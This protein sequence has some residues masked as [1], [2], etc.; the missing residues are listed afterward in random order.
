[1]NFS[2][3][4]GHFSILLFLSFFHHYEKFERGEIVFSPTS[5]LSTPLTTDRSEPE[6]RVGSAMSSVAEENQQVTLKSINF[7]VFQ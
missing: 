4:F 7:V 6:L 2:S 1:M 3:G 5:E